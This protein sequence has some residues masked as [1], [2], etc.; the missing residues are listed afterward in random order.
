MQT[1]IAKFQVAQVT[2]QSETQEEIKMFPVVNKPFDAD[3][4]SDDNDFARW[5]PSGS[6]SITIANPN[7]I[8]KFKEGQK[9]YLNFTESEN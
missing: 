4:K 5:S 7:L 9:F 1:M 8:G 3:G 6:L 2:K